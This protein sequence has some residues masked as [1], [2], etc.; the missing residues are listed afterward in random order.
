MFKKPQLISIT[1]FS[2]FPLFSMFVNSVIADDQPTNE[3]LMKQLYSKIAQVVAVDI[4]SINKVGTYLVLEP[5]G[6]TLIDDTLDL[7]K[8]EDRET[9]RSMFANICLDESWIK[10]TRPDSLL[11]VY[12]KI[13]EHHETPTYQ[14]TVEQNNRYKFLDSLLFVDPNKRRKSDLYTI[15]DAKEET[16]TE[17][18]MAVEIYRNENKTASVPTTLLMRL[19]KA[20]RE[21]EIDAQ[22][23]VVQSYIREHRELQKLLGGDWKT[24]LL[25]T[26]EQN[27]HSTYFYPSYP[28]WFN[29][30]K[31][32][33]KIKTEQKNLLKITRNENT[34]TA[35]GL[36]GGWGVFSIGIYTD[37]GREIKTETEDIKNLNLSFEILPVQ[38]RHPWIDYGVFQARNWR[39]RRNSTSYGNIISDG[40]FNGTPGEMLPLIPT[41]LLIARN[42][43]LSADWSSK[44][45][46]Y[47]KESAKTQGFVGFGP[48][49]L[50]G[51]TNPQ[52]EESY[53]SEKKTDNSIVFKDPQVIGC[54]A[55]LVPI[56]PNPDP[57][58]PWRDS[59]LVKDL[60]GIKV[61]SD[62]L[63]LQAQK[64][65]SELKPE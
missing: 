37:K 8:T 2:L 5:A 45:D 31:T 15:F 3:D 57:K 62:S 9:L 4:N 25:K 55:H 54:L 64:L 20:K 41:T 33:G 23:P 19:E 32:W 21:Y 17:A 42:V 22:G 10:S 43:E 27:M 59:P 60:L 50:A 14:M 11:T 35:G 26:F 1:F 16:L 12:N 65:L 30:E 49:I 40:M 58:L 29:K 38:I 56:S 63:T 52:N 48:F 39:W 28:N 34:S 36:A 61:E 6:G 46:N 47:F 18:I 44:V 51:R 7:S 24:E 53:K 13:I